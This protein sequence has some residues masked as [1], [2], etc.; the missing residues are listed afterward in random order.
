VD[1]FPQGFPTKTNNILNNAS[2]EVRTNLVIIFKRGVGPCSFVCLFI[3]V[4]VHL[5]ACSFVCLF[6]RVLVHLCACSF[7]CLFIC[8]LVH[9]CGITKAK[10]WIVIHK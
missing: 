6:I 5:C 7:V 9:L 8:V 2:C 10:T 1:Y 3:C 4:L